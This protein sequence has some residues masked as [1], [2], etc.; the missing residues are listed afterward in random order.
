MQL[1]WYGNTCGSGLA[2]ISEQDDVKYISPFKH[3][4]F[5]EGCKKAQRVEQ[6]QGGI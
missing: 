3:P 2:Q 5:K 1:L 4:P 6:T